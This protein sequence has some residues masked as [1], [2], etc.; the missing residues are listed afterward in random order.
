MNPVVKKFFAGS[1]VILMALSVFGYT[2][3]STN[4]FY[5][6]AEIS[7]DND[8]NAGSLD[9]A[10]IASG[11]WSPVSDVFDLLPGDTVVR[12]MSVQN[13]GSLGFEY[14]ASASFVDLG[15]TDLCPFL[16]LTVTRN[17]STI[18]TGLLRNLNTSGTPFSLA[19]GSN[20]A[21]LF[22]ASIPSG[23]P[24][25]DEDAACQ[26]EFIFDAFMP[27][28]GF[29]QGFY[30]REI[31]DGNLFETGGW[32]IPTNNYSPIADARIE[33]DNP[34]NNFDFSV[35]LGVLADS[36]IRQT[37]FLRFELNLPASAIVHSAEVNLFMYNA[38]DVDSRTYNAH[39][40]TVPWTESGITWAASASSEAI[41]T[42]SAITGTTDGTWLNW[43]VVSDVQGFTNGSLTN[44]GWEIRDANSGSGEGRFRSRESSFGERPFLEVNFTAPAAPTGYVVINEVHAD[45]ASG[46]ET[47]NE[48]VELYNPTD[49]SIDLTGW[50]ICDNSACD[51]FPGTPSIPAKGFAVV[52]NDAST[53]NTHW[54]QILATGATTI[55]LGS[56]IGNLLS[57]SDDRVI[58]KDTSSVVVD[59]I[60]YGSDT[61]IL[62]P[63][64]PFA[65]EGD[66]IARVVKGYDAD[67]ATDWLL[68]ATPN[69]GTNPSASGSEVMRVTSEGIMVADAAEGF[70]PLAEEEE[71][72]T[73]EEEPGT[74][75]VL[76]PIPLF[77]PM[78]ESNPASSSEELLVD[79]SNPPTQIASDG[80]D[81]TP[82]PTPT[83]TPEPDPSATPT[84][85]ASPSP[86]PSPTPSS[87]PEASPSPTPDPSVT[88]T[89]SV[90]P[91]PTP[92]ASPSPEPTTTPEPSPET[93]PAPTPEP[94]PIVIPDPP[95][96][97]EVP[98][99][100]PVEVQPPAPNP[101]P[102]P[103]SE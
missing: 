47:L 5:G 45:V 61:T 67:V 62:N 12:G 43:N 85:E 66:S 86:E 46:S 15:V 14:T 90:E 63:S 96:V 56:P 81:V 11:S 95:Q 53:W 48:W 82:T 24:E 21:W 42:G 2:A 64:I 23:A 72:A 54:T 84:P 103:A 25:L 50:Q 58:L 83:P 19:S 57:N 91:E 69:P 93:T 79:P 39:R 88:P 30:D 75:K 27:A 74:E 4:A 55:A 3:P 78:P 38:P 49:L 59:Q 60:S 33:E 102:A 18:Y 13:V 73:D 40:V 17:A 31:V 36:S 22:S 87:E 41:P 65:N 1:L 32:V 29:G 80:E 89:P 10:I 7:I 68:N 20:D 52:A 76:E 9:L 28:L 35:R 98:S 70:D 99:A 6:D 51:T 101:D 97:V 16:N 44:N 92:N 26:V 94:D 34:A 100:P 77:T 37:S 71:P 8:F